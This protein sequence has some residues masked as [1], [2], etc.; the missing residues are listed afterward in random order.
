MYWI[1]ME[2]YLS[3][4]KNIQVLWATVM[5]KLISLCY[6]C[7]PLITVML[8][9]LICHQIGRLP[10]CGRLASSLFLGASF[11]SHWWIQ[12]RVTVRK[13]PI[14]VKTNDF[15]AMWPWNFTDDLEKQQGTSSKW[16]QALCIISL[17]YVNSN[18][19]YAPVT[20]KL[21]FDLCDRDLSP[22]TLTFCM[23]V[24]FVNGNNSWEFYD[25]TMTGT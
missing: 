6:H 18:W 22:L 9:I 12:T 7:G 2:N 24:T 1:R 10:G 15:L 25:D 3:R 21:G 23:D 14:W 16:H 20:A 5:T 19:S 17:L 8:K 4:D 13:R 11:H